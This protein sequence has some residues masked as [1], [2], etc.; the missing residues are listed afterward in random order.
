MLSVGSYY[1]RE[2]A[3]DEEETTTSQEGAFNT[4]GIQMSGTAA[5]LLFGRAPY[6]P[7]VTVPLSRVAVSGDIADLVGYLTTSGAAISVLNTDTATITTLQN[8]SI[9]TEQITTGGQPIVCDWNNVWAQTSLPFDLSI[10]HFKTRRTAMASQA[11][12]L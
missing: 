7:R 2:S 9:D 1:P 6:A 11:A 3:G 5:R 12:C 4:V 10:T 8:Q